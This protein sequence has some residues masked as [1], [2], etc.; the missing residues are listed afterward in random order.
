M[1][2]L[3]QVGSARAGWRSWLQSRLGKAGA[4]AVALAT[5]ASVP[6]L[7]DWF[8]S[9]EEALFKM[10]YKKNYSD[11][12]QTIIN[13]H[14]DATSLFCKAGMRLKS[15]DVR[16]VFDDRYH[17]AATVKALTGGGCM[18]SNHCPTALKDMPVYVG[19]AAHPDKRQHLKTLCGR[20]S[21]VHAIESNIAAERQKLQ[22]NAQANAQR[23]QRLQRCV[24][25][26]MAEGG[27]KLMREASQFNILGAQT[28]T[29]R[30]CVLAK[31]NVFL[32]TWRPGSGSADGVVVKAA[33]ECCG[34]Y[35]PA[36]PETNAAM[37]Q[38]R[39][40]LAMLQ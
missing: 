9:P 38:A 6:A 7:N 33:N 32:L 31:L 20:A 29:L 37:D 40:A 30:Q 35:D 15:E 27:E 10:G 19:A 39:Q 18:D 8:A 23:P 14:P 2:D 24:G 1:P 12:V 36:V 4:A 26:F 25:S 5:I 34:S 28:Y 3:A 11:F 17:S 16:L 13:K 21:V 22:G